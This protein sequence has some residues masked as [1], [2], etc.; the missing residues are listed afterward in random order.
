MTCAWS[1]T[2]ASYSSACLAIPA[3]VGLGDIAVVRCM[4]DGALDQAFEGGGRTTVDVLGG[5]DIARR[6]AHRDVGAV[7]IAGEALNPDTGN[8]RFAVLRVNQNGTL[9]STFNETGVTWSNTSQERM[10][11]R[12]RSSCSTTERSSR[13]VTRLNQM[14]GHPKQRSPL[15]GRRCAPSISQW[16]DLTALVGSMKASA[17]VARR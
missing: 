11:R 4:S 16:H 1:P 5:E 6:V 12:E 10:R 8:L 17:R 13:R 15:P 7:V 9:D 14:M 2:V 3:Q